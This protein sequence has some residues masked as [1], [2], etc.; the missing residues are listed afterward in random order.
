[1][2]RTD[3]RS[4]GGNLASLPAGSRGKIAGIAARDDTRRELYSLGFLEGAEI[5]VIRRAPRGG[6]VLVAVGASQY[7]L[8]HDVAAAIRVVPG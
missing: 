5:R 6:A 8:G 2:P 7:A 4:R 3:R 1:M